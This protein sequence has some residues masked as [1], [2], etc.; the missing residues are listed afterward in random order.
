MKVEGIT[1]HDRKVCD[2]PCPFHAPSQHPL[3]DARM[4][5]RVDKYCLVERICEHGIGHDDPD[6]VRYMQ[7]HGLKWAGVHGCD[8]CCSGKRL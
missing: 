5:I 8:G 6:S 3:R 2:A 4:H 1:V 7:K